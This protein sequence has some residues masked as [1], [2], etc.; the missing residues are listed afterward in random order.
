M[1]W[2]T[3]FTALFDDNQ[4]INTNTKLKSNVLVQYA[5][6]SNLK[7]NLPEKKELLTASCKSSYS[8]FSSSVKVLVKTVIL[9]KRG[10]FGIF[11]FF[12]ALS[13]SVQPS[14]RDEFQKIAR[15]QS[16]IR[17]V[18]NTCRTCLILCA[19]TM[20]PIKGDEIF[21]MAVN[22]GIDFLF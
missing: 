18:W 8:T 10:H 1:W 17:L 14:N 5:I 13:F 11:F 4:M 2:M 6:M 21:E 16:F 9:F 7:P 22:V 12:C 3:R 15:L 19:N 20:P